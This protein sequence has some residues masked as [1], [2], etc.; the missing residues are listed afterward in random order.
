MPD[1]LSTSY[2]GLCLHFI[3]SVC[4]IFVFSVLSF[5]SF[6]M[7]GLS[8]KYTDRWDVHHGSNNECITEA[9][10]LFCELFMYS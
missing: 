4:C 3:W 10:F 6:Y 5:F 9:R 1:F 7:S 8:G 2:W